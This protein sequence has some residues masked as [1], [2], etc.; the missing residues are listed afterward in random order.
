MKKKRGE[1]NMTGIWVRE[2]DSDVIGIY[3]K[4]FT[5]SLYDS[6]EVGISGVNLQGKTDLLG[7]FESEEV[8]SSVMSLIESFINSNNTL[9]FTMPTSNGYN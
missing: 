7:I 4:F 1:C 6:N 3:T 9:V 8:A 5:Y 2:Q